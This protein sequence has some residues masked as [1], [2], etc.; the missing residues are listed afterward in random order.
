MSADFECA[1]SR[2]QRMYQI[3]HNP[4]LLEDGDI[5]YL[6]IDEKVRRIADEKRTGPVDEEGVVI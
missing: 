6:K 2:C 1:K 5:D 3:L 4:D